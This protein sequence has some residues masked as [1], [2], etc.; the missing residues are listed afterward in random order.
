MIFHPIYYL[1]FLALGVSIWAQ[2]KVKGNF[3]KWSQIE[4]QTGLSGANVARKILNSNGLHHISIEAI[5][6]SLSDNYDPI[7]KVIRLSESV[8]YGR[9][10]ASVSHE[11]GHAIQHLRSYPALVI[12]HRI[13]PFVNL[14]SGIAPF[15]FGGGMLLGQLSVSGIGIIFFSVA[16]VFQLVTL[17]V[18]FDA[19]KRARNLMLTEG[20]LYKSE[21]KG[22]K[23]V[24]NAVALKYV[25]ATIISVFEIIK[26]V[27]LF[28]QGKQK[29]EH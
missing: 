9:S 26:F 13:F 29:E 25:A 4:T 17:P 10:I 23:K 1:L 3:N 19:S 6:G 12:R 22:V 18:E 16:V 2:F 28:F 11:V 20:I 5:Q 14:A 27:L 7:Q 24:L 21:E 8:Y 15:L